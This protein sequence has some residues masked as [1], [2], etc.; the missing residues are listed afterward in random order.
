[1]KL[2][3][4]LFIS[5]LFVLIATMSLPIISN[6]AE[7]HSGA[8]ISY[9]YCDLDVVDFKSEY[10][11]SFDCLLKC[12][13]TISLENTNKAK[14][15]LEGAP[16]YK[17]FKEAYVGIRNSSGKWKSD[18]ASNS[19]KYKVSAS[20]NPIAFIPV[21]TQHDLLYY[22]AMDEGSGPYRMHSRIYS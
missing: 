20:V 19:N 3:K 13:T 7:T 2:K 4:R 10:S 15:S 1:M 18:T 8:R 5:F 9:E 12:D 14:T 16:S 21:Y 11:E 6:A 17:T 22:E